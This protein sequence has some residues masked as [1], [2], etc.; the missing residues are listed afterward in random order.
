MQRQGVYY[1]DY[2]RVDVASYFCARSEENMTFAPEHLQDVGD[3]NFNAINGIDRFQKGGEIIKVTGI[4]VTNSHALESI[5][6]AKF[7]EY[8]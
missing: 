1:I 2:F 7:G 3:Y 6:D 8:E 5:F 4:L